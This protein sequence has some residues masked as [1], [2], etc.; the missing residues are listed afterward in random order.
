MKEVMTLKEVAQ[1]LQLAEKSVLRMAQAGKIPAAKIASQ[2]R[3]LRTLVNDWLASQMELAPAEMTQPARQEPYASLDELLDGE[4]TA[5]SVRAGIKQEVLSQLVEPLER[6]GRLPKA[7]PFLNSLVNREQL[8]STAVGGGVA[9]PHPR[10][11][12]RGLFREPA[13]VVGICKEGAEFASV[14]GRPVHVFFLICATSEE[15]HLRLMAQ[16]SYL[17]RKPGIVTRLRECAS[18]R[19]VVEMVVGAQSE[20]AECCGRSIRGGRIRRPQA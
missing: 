10:T 14:D 1:Y 2:W 3:F 4:L 5:L 13:I 11:P 19:A 8:A 15:E 7:G 6:S 17:L 16:L 9:I 12:V 20:E 18:G